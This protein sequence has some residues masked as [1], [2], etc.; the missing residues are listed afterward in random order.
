MSEIWLEHPNLPGQHIKVPRAALGT[1]ARSGW[2]ERADQSDPIDPDTT[3]DEPAPE[4]DEAD[5]D[6]TAAGSSTE[7]PPNADDD[8]VADE[9]A[10]SSTTKK[11]R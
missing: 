1:Y 5:V 11:G 8:P 3:V 7:E 9:P 4:Q 6:D 2:Q 10:T